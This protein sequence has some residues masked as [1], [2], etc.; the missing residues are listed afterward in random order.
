M[1]DLCRN[2]NFFRFRS[3]KAK[4]FM[5][6][7]HLHRAAIMRPRMEIYTRPNGTG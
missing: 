4:G 7:D 2:G 3:S 5:A 6:M 1:V